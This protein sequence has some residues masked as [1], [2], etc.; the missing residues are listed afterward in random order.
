MRLSSAAFSNSGDGTGMSVS[1]GRE[2]QEAGISPRRALTRF[3][4]F[5]L[6][7]LFASACRK[8]RQ[9]IQRDPTAEDPHHALVNGEKPKS[10]QKSLARTAT[11]LVKPKTRE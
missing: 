8:H 11:V 6:A 3:P 9:A 1:L 10:V 4:R 7:S 5:G 2:A